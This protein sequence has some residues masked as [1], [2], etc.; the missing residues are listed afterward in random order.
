MTEALRV[1][2][3]LGLAATPSFVIGPQAYQGYLNLA[4]KR[5]LIAKARA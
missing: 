2:S 5:A 3:S 4:H 1:G